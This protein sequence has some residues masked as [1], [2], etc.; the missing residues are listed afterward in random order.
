MNTQNAYLLKQNLPGKLLAA[1]Q[2]RRRTNWY[3]RKKL[4]KKTENLQGIYYEERL[5]DR[6][7]SWMLASV[8][9]GWSCHAR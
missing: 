5:V 6:S 1:E 7:G 2:D 8:H 9:G 4:E 3:L